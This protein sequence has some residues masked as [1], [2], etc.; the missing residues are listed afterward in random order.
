MQSQDTTSRARVKMQLWKTAAIRTS[1]QDRTG[2]WNQ[3]TTMRSSS[4]LLMASEMIAPSQR[5]SKSQVT[6]L[7]QEVTPR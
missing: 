5:V 3:E 6:T 4:G 7:E 1:V 2:Q